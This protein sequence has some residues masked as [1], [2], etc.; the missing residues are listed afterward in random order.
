MCKGLRLWMRYSWEIL[1]DE[2]NN[3]PNHKNSEILRIQVVKKDV[4]SKSMADMFLP[5]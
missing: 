5:R 4:V 1:R 2:L 3:F